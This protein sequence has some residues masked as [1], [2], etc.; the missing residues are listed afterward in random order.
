MID[1]RLVDWRLMIEPSVAEPALSII[2]PAISQSSF[3]HQ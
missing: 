1:G 2:N 3:N